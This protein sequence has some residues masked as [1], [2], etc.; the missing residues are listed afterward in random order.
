MH[1]YLIVGPK[2]ARKDQTEKILKKERIDP[3]EIILLEGETGQ[4]HSIEEIRYLIRRLSIKPIV[5]DARRAIVIVDAQNLTEEAANAFLKTLEEPP[6]DTLILLS[7]TNQMLLPATV[8]S[9]C[10]VIEARAFG[11]IDKKSLPEQE[12]VFLKLTRA[13]IGERIRFCE[14]LGNSRDESIAFCEDQLI[15]IR[16]LLLKSV[17]EESGKIGNLLI[18]TRKL[19]QTLANLKSNVNSKMLLF[20]L[21]LYY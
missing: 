14:L 9:R 21:L 6:G 2:L 8:V 18:L 19:A 3:R 17:K 11:K 1:A 20:D 5:K 13:G 15:L 10:Q 12:E 7:A 4:A 16:S